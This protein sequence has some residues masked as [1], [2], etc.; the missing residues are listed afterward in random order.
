[1]KIRKSTIIIFLLI[2]SLA[3]ITSCASVAR[4]TISST[5]S[6]ERV[7]N[8]CVESAG[9]VKFRVYDSNMEAGF[10]Y[11]VYPVTLGGMV[12]M[13]INVARAAGEIKVAV[14]VELPPD[15]VGSSKSTV[16]DF[17]KA[18]KKRILDVKVESVE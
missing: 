16:N 15:V 2:S 8:A 11:A 3:F 6:Y 13:K 18:L 7:F 4:G 10:I 5:T 9:D 1:M 17:A 14:A 12:Q